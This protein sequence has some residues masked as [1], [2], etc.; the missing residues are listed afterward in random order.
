MSKLSA[1]SLMLL[2]LWASGIFFSGIL[3][4]YLS[5]TGLGAATVLVEN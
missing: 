1:E 3:E 2:M 4:S 5:L